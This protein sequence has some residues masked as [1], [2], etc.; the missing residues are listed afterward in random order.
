MQAEEN[1]LSVWTDILEKQ[2]QAS[3]EVQ[4]EDIEK[5]LSH[6]DEKKDK[7]LYGLC[8]FYMA[9]FYLKNGSQDECLSYL[10]E[11]IRC[12]MGT[13]QEKQLSRCY[14]I[15]GIIAHGQN[16]LLLAAEQ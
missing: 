1:G 6:I 12:M 7:G 4:M 13:E 5:A 3:G 10:N 9:F 15:L 16:K 11:S 14:N 8:N 2:I